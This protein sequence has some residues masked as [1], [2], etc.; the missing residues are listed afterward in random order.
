MTLRIL[1]VVPYFCPAFGGPVSVVHN[2][3]RELGKR[4]HKVSV[5]TTDI[6][7]PKVRRGISDNHYHVNGF[8]VQCFKNVLGLS[9]FYFSSSMIQFAIK[10]V[11]K[12]D[13]I[14]LHG[15]RTFPNVVIAHYARKYGVP[16]V[17]QAHGSLPRIMAW[18]RLKWV[19][20]VLFGY[21]L[22]R[23]EA[24]QYKAMGVPEEKI[25][26]IPNGIALSEYAKLPP[27]GAFKRKFNMDENEKIILY[28]GR[29]HRIKGVDVL[30]KAFA[31]VVEKWD[32]VR[33]SRRT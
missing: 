33:I 30:V 9:S 12:F 32:D 25:A 4:N 22:L 21:R 5:C 27:K 17:L 28:L 7:S 24:Q 19:Y 23:E 26:V 13:V 11:P 2:L 15:Y 18:R 10:E 14:H 20:D 8:Y 3:S 6:Q 31:D 1:Q 29:I 16:Y